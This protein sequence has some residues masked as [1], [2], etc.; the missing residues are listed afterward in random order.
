MNTSVIP[1]PEYTPMAPEDMEIANT[2]LE[3]MDINLTAS[4]LKI[5]LEKVT[6]YINKQQVQKYIT[7]VFMN[8]GYRNRLKLGQVLDNIIDK[9]LQELEESETTSSKD[10]IDILEMVAK[11]R[12]DERDHERKME[13]LRLGGPKR[14]TNIQINNAPHNPYSEFTQKLLDLNDLK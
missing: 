13:E 12:K 4:N 1:S 10:I 7:T 6:E 14:Q 9:K 11:I 5:P 8:T 2:F 3:T